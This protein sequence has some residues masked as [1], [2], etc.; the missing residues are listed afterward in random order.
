MTPFILDVL[1]SCRVKRYYLH[2]TTSYL[3]LNCSLVYSCINS[4]IL[5]VSFSFEQEQHLLTPSLTS[6]H[7]VKNNSFTVWLVQV[8]VTFVFPVTFI[9]D[10]EYYE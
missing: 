10:P 6:K 9:E 2:Q 1:S 4:D 5:Y 8:S 3:L 7:Q